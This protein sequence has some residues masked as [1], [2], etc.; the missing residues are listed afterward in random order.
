MSLG[1]FGVSIFMIVEFV[2]G[3]GNFPEDNVPKYG[4]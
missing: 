2:Y 4:P 3:L 1:V